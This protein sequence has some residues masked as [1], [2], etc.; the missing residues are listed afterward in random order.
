[1]DKY[2]KLIGTEFLNASRLLKDV[3]KPLEQK[4]AL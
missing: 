4:A 1:M 3:L 2:G